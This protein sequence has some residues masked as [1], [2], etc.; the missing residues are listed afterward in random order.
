MKLI[1][2]E[3]SNPSLRVLLNKEVEMK[4]GELL[5]IIGFGFGWALLVFNGMVIY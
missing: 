1:A 5:A 4:I 3:D 2:V